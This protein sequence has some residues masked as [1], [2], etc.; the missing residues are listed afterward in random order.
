VWGVDLPVMIPKPLQAMFGQRLFEIVR[1]YHQRT[2]ICVLRA[3]HGLAELLLRLVEH[4]IEPSVVAG[5]SLEAKILAAE[6]VAKQ[7]LATAFGVDEFAAATGLSRSRFSALYKQYRGVS[8]G[9]FLRRERMQ[10]A[11]EL[12]ART[13][14]PVAEVGTLVGYPEPTAF[15]RVFRAHTGRAPSEWRRLAL[16]KSQRDEAHLA[17]EKSR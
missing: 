8:P 2:E 1:T 14:L 9:E 5:A 7:N 13:H 10:A 15:G 6:H 3:T 16:P 11:V 12:L 4:V 17:I